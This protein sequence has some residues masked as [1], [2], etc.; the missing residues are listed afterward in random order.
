MVA[1]QEDVNATD[2]SIPE[3][4]PVLPSGGN[5][6]YPSIMV[7]V[8]TGEPRVLKLIDDAVADNK[9]IALFAERDQEAAGHANLYRIGTAAH[10]A[11]MLKWPDGSIQLYL[12]GLAR[13]ELKEITQEDPYL[14]GKV[15][16]K[17][18][19]PEE[20]AEL[21]ALS[22]NLLTLFQ[23]VVQLAPNLPQE[24]GAAVLNI[25]K[26][27]NL[28][29][30]IASH[31][32]ITTEESQELLETIS[33]AER[34]RKL[35]G[36]INREL[37]LLELGSKIQTQI[38]G[39]MD[40]AQREYYLREQLKAIQKEL[41]EGDEHTTEL[42]EL[43]EKIEEAQLPEEAMKEAERELDR[44]SRMHPAAAEYSVARTY[45]DWLISLPW[46]KSTEDHLDIAE[47][48][49]VL[50]TDHYD[51][52]KVKD[53][54]LDYLAVHKLRH[55]M[56]GPILCFVGPP[57]TGKTSVGHSVARA[58][59]REFVRMSLGGMHDEAEIRGHR[60][61]Y[62][63]ALPGRII[64]GIRRAESNNPVFMLDEIDK[65]GADFRGDPASAL[66]EVLDPE[67]NHAFV[68]H[69]L[70]VPFDFSKVMFITTANMLDPIPPALKDRMEVIELVG[71]TEQEKLQIARNYLVPRQ[72]VENGLT[73]DKLELSDEVLLRIISDYTREAGVR[74]LEREIGSVC[75]KVARKVAEGISEIP[76]VMPDKLHDYLGP[77]RF[78]YELAGEA[79]EVGVATGMAWTI[80][81]GDVLF[82]EASLIPGKGD[83][84][85]TGKLGDVMQESA[86]A[87]LTYVRSRASDFGIDADFYKKKDVHIHVPAGAIPKDGPSAGVTMAVALVSAATKLPVSKDIAMTGE[88]TLRGKVL[89]VGGIKEKV[90]AAH[91][92]GIK[93][94]ILPKENEKDLE[95]IPQQVKDE[96]EFFFVER[97]DDA[98]M[99][100]IH[101]SPSRKTKAPKKSIP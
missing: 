30:F 54:V 14:R 93:S 86:R 78:R 6:L 20:S 60:R 92:A 71:Y 80:A 55:D 10:I 15:E 41:G 23:K 84:V 62:V 12:R 99:K 33:V 29:D 8:A 39:E 2:V 53:R 24:V 27:S 7:P 56:K 28:T 51:L 89:P 4:L 79:D 63:G 101:P 47:A 96:L 44:L 35:T 32:N 18:E 95:E 73:A 94:V 90:L 57:G 68:D 1:K 34:I 70:D 37:E 13:I 85:I 64:Q 88:I 58:L 43:R 100:T 9:L 67:Q 48:K 76:Q 97:I 19:V 38:K 46:A 59:G 45:I 22:R 5:I 74:N 31:L 17:E 98:I 52:E 25:P 49:E 61:T 69:Y 77:D 81:G 66:L 26:P 40:K 3:E 36:Y 11:R 42:N 75:R 87:T 50:D 16:V 72:L 83:F 91:R 21:A 65:V 82:V